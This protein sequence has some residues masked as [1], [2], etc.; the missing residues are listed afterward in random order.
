MTFK[1]SIIIVNWDTCKLVDDC[2]NSIASNQIS[3]STETIVVDNASTDGSIE[4]VRTKYP[5]AKLIENK[6]NV[7]FAK[8]NNQGFKESSGRY[9]MFLNS[10]TI[11][12]LHAIDKIIKFMEMHP[13]VDIVGPKLL[14]KDGSLQISAFKLPTLFNSVGD[15]IFGFFDNPFSSRFTSKY[16]RYDREIQVGW[17]SGACLVAK[18][19][20][21]EK[22]GGWDETFFMYSEDIVMGIKAKQYGLKTSFFPGA[23]II[24]LR[25][26]SSKAS[27]KRIMQVYESRMKLRREHFDG[28]SFLIYLLATSLIAFSRAIVYSV[29]FLLQKLVGIEASFARERVS[30]YMKVAFLHIKS[31]FGA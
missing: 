9:V 25:N 24:H 13:E 27:Q 4:M 8:A 12:K 3:F 26:K 28:P 21:I 17:V 6:E 22:I 23:E 2:L 11:V 10:D 29:R 30:I 7:G 31:A 14:N 15:L 20:A 19:E 18:R 5:Q 1:L 16:S